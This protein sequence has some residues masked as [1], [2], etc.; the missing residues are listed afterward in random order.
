MNNILISIMSPY[1]EIHGTMNYDFMHYICKLSGWKGV[2][3]ATG[4][5]KNKPDSDNT[6]DVIDV[7]NGRVSD[8]NN[9]EFNQDLMD[10]MLAV[11]TRYGKI[12]NVLYFQDWHLQRY[13]GSFSEGAKVHYFIRLFVNDMLRV[14]NSE[15]VKNYP[16]KQH[17]VASQNEHW[18]YV[19]LIEE[20]RIKESDQIIVA[21]D[22]V[23]D[24]LVS[25]YNLEQEKIVTINSYSD[26]IPYIRDNNSFNQYNNIKVIAP[27]RNDLQK[28]LW[29][30]ENADRIPVVF[31]RPNLNLWGNRDSLT[32]EIEKQNTNWFEE[33]TDIP[34]VVFPAAYETRGLLVQE[35]MANGRIV[36]VSS[37]SPGLCEQVQHGITGFVVNFDQDWQSQIIRIVH[38]YGVNKLNQISI[39]AR[40]HILQEFYSNNF[41][42]ALVNYMKDLM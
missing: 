6:I 9:L 27:G 29:K 40:K 36:F 22:T 34:Y 10:F 11:R 30:L 32:T 12:D 31:D 18:Q 13:L 23:K 37:S 7:P 2:V 41:R 39:A 4:S 16:E 24:S 15:V 20:Q 1:T 21:T 19:K 3:F 14:L 8:F 35:A 42:Q 26:K 5:I 38:E 17:Q 33:Y 28:G 25:L